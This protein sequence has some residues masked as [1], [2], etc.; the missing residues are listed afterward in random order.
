MHAVD[1]RN[2]LTQIISL[3]CFVPVSQQSTEEASNDGREFTLMAGFPP[4]DL[5]TDMDSTIES[6]KLSGEAITM[7]WK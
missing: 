3:F 1:K 4:R 6:C 5:S 7:R 2:S